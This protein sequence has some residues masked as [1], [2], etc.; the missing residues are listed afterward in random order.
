[1]IDHEFL[2]RLLEKGN[3]KSSLF[4]KMFAGI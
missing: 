1:M 3:G 4:N 2:K